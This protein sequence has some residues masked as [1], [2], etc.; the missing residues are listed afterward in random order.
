MTAEAALGAEMEEH[1]GYGM[2]QRT[3]RLILKFKLPILL[4]TQHQ[5]H[6]SSLDLIEPHFPYPSS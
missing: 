2:C 4:A 3:C 1:L 6:L 5:L